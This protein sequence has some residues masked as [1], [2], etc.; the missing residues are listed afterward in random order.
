MY[1]NRYFGLV[2]FL[3]PMLCLGMGEAQEAAETESRPFVKGG[4]Y[5]KPHLFKLATGKAT[6]G[7]Y[8]EAHFRFEKEEGIV[9][10]NSRAAPIPS[11][12]SSGPA[13]RRPRCGSLP[14]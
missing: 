6:F 1:R 8:A 2:A 9:E 14:G 4:A 11:P 10:E 5:D 3:L 12:T 13:A 7:G